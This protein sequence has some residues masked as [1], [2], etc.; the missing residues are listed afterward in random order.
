MLNTNPLSDLADYVKR[1]ET[2]QNLNSPA[3]LENA[4][5]V[6]RILKENSS[7]A[8]NPAWFKEPVEKTLFDEISKIISKAD[9]GV[10]LTEL[11]SLNPTVTKFFNDVLVMDKDENV[12]KNRL[13]L[14]TLLKNKYEY[15]TDFSRL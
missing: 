13:A 12:K 15:L 11:E 3:L 4:N 5:R 14:L 1:V 2:V 6:I 9:Y 10:Y 8:V 7:D